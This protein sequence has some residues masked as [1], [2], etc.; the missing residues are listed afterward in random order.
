MVAFICKVSLYVCDFSPFVPLQM[1]HMKICSALAS[2]VL[3]LTSLAAWYIAVLS[4]VMTCATITATGRLTAPVTIWKSQCGGRHWRHWTVSCLLCMIT[5]LTRHEVWR[6][7]LRQ[8]LQ[9]SLGFKTLSFKNSL[10][11]KDSDLWHHH[12]IFN[13]NILQNR[14]FLA[15]VVVV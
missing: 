2:L 7:R 14:T 3:L 9:W 10:L 8:S 4:C 11:L 1:S 6:M 5:G 12:D 15:E 13:M